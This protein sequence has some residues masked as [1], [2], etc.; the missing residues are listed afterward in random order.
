MGSVCSES[1]FCGFSLFKNWFLWIRLSEGVHLRA[2]SNWTLSRNP[3]E[4]YV[5]VSLYILILESVIFHLSK[6]LAFVFE[7][8]CFLQHEIRAPRLKQSKHLLPLKP[9]PS[10]PPWVNQIGLFGICGCRGLEAPALFL[11]LFVTFC[12]DIIFFGG[13]SLPSFFN[14]KVCLLH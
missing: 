9:Y 4:D 7:M 6:N 13:D 2:N 1:F 14:I 5:L 12:F 8:H 3:G 10:I 11:S